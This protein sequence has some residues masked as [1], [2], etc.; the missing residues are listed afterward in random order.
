MREKNREGFIQDFLAGRGKADGPHLT[1]KHF[2]IIGTCRSQISYN[3]YNMDVSP[4]FVFSLSFLST[5]REER[6]IDCWCIG[7]SSTFCYKSFYF[8]KNPMRSITKKKVSTI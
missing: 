2:R 8:Q 6:R 3:L 7:P 1:G 4:V 5:A